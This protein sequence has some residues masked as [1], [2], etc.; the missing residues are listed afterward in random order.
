MNPEASP[1]PSGAS[2]PSSPA[3]V[4]LRAGPW[5]LLLW[6]GDIRCLRLGDRE[7]IRRVYAAVRDAH[8]GT[9]PRH[10]HELSVE[11]SEAG[12][13]VRQQRTDG[14]G[15]LAVAISV[16]ITG[17]ADGTVTYL[18]EAV[19]Q[20]TFLANRLGLCVLHPLREGAGA[21]CRTR[22]T[23]GTR[24]EL[25]FPG[26]VAEVQP[27]P[28]FTDLVG[29]DHEIHPETWAELEFEGEIFETEDQRNWTDASFKTYS[30]PIR[31]PF[32]FE[33]RQGHRIRQQVTLR[34]PAGA[35]P[36]SVS[37]QALPTPGPARVL[38][39]PGPGIRLPE[40]GLG[41]ASHGLPLSEPEVDRLSC[42][43][44]SHLRVDLRLARD[45]WVERLRSAARDALE[46]GAALE[47]A[48]HLP[49]DA[50]GDLRAL[51]KELGRLR[52]DL[53]RAILLREGQRSTLP[54]D[55]EEARQS[56]RECGMALGAGT[57][58]DLF[59]L[60]LQKPPAGADFI[61]WSMNPQVH[62]TDDL[63]IAETP[64]GAAHQV[65]SVHGYF[66]GR[67][68]VVSPVTLKPRPPTH[69]S[70]RGTGETEALEQGRLPRT[71]DPRQR[72]LLAAA[73]TVGM[74][75][76]LCEGG[77]ESLTLFETTGWRGVL[78]ISAGSL[79]PQL[80]PSRPGEVFPVY[81]VLADMAEFSQGT[82]RPT[83]VL[84]GDGLVA[85]R[86]AAHGRERLLLANLGRSPQSVSVEVSGGIDRIRVL[87]GN[88]M[89]EAANSPDDFR[90]GQRPFSPGFTR[91]ELGVHACATLDV[92]LA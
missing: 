5:S 72:G 19:A 29:L 26:T 85:F 77:I 7:V 2:P 23:D 10:V 4:P 69:P 42:L 31:F 87:D 60:N 30:R 40:W 76:A 78:E 25:R 53:T 54:G 82:T 75:K 33:I 20:T 71:V 34:P 18:L 57:D 28:G 15:D 58:G 27:I 52:V 24:R 62:A 1:A 66:P 79:H 47:L 49:E 37:V 68:L 67:P 91:L 44:L 17:R 64:E 51:A 90:R 6:D 21:R 22:H 81:H 12:F 36:A 61:S 48:I 89:A 63:S 9:L 55:L 39:E 45:T 74:L 65:A 43:G 38:C 56:L 73:W 3:A 13:R 84:D 35:P 41:M 92:S 32:P 70:S 14:E 16:D 59:Q 46:L 83:R 86:L 88:S 11:T 8:W 80:F 50:P